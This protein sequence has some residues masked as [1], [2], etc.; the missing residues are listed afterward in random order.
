MGYHSDN[1]PELGPRP[2]IASIS[3]GDR[4]RF[5]LRHR[6]S[7]ERWSWDLGQGDLLV[8]RDESQSDYGHAVPKT[9]RPV[10]PRMNLTF[11]RFQ[12]RNG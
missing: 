9:T 1:E 2:T 11:R 10:E 3:L 4:R 7:G 12:P 6:T 5:V 8:M